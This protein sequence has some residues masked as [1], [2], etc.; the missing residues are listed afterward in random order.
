MKVGLK[1]AIDMIP[2]VV[3]CF[4]FAV[5]ESC[6]KYDECDVSACNVFAPNVSH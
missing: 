2:D 3:D 1:N 4:D 5:N 6:I